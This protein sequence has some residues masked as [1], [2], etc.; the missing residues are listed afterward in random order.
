MWA[1]MGKILDKN[2]K[3]E[4]AFIDS[5]AARGYPYDRYHT[6]HKKIATIKKKSLKFYIDDN[7]QVKLSIPDTIST[8]TELKITNLNLLKL[9][10]WILDNVRND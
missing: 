2:L 4:R 10:H 7:T 5:S 8:P 1:K 9:A 3:E 6:D